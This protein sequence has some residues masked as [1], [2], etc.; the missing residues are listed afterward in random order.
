[1]AL[2]RKIKKLRLST[3]TWHINLTVNRP[4]CLR[5]RFWL[6]HYLDIHSAQRRSDELEWLTY[7]CEV[8]STRIR[9]NPDA[10]RHF[11]LE[12]VVVGLPPRRAEQK[13]AFFGRSDNYD[14]SFEEAQE[15]EDQV[16]VNGTTCWVKR[17]DVNRI[18][19]RKVV[20][21]DDEAGIIKR[22]LQIAWGITIV[23][24]VIGM[25][26]MGLGSHWI[27][28]LTGTI[29]VPHRVGS[30]GEDGRMGRKEEEKGLTKAQTRT[31][32]DLMGCAMKAGDD[33]L[34]GWVCAVCLE[35]EA[36][37]AGGMIWTILLSCGHRFHGE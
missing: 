37:G 2:L 4:S 26:C 1:M 18:S 12:A 19:L 9:E 10:P 25:L 6:M 11:R 5:P 30:I 28:E 3:C 32:C 21:T 13:L 36:E 7:S 14:Q 29:A 27:Y 22:R 15:L 20:L 17:L 24:T 31:L 33:K 23:A 8:N 34:K 35:E 16:D